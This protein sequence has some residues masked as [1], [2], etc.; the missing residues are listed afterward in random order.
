MSWGVLE[1]I[2]HKL[3]LESCMVRLLMDVNKNIS[4]I[5]K[6]S[7]VCKNLC[8]IRSDTLYP[9]REPERPRKP[10]NALLDAYLPDSFRFHLF[11]FLHSLKDK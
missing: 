10:D 9:T 11:L 3:A 6:N 2:K 4:F 8:I 5:T 7:H 1:I